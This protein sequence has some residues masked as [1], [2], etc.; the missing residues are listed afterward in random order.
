[1][2]VLTG[3]A[4]RVRTVAF[5]PDGTTLASSAGRGTRVWLWDLSTGKVRA[6][7]RTTHHRLECITFSAAAGLMATRDH[8]GGVA[9]W[10]IGERTPLHI[11]RN[12]WP[13]TPPGSWSVAF[14]PDGTTLATSGGS[15]SQPRNLHLLFF[16]TS[17]GEERRTVRLESYLFSLA[18]SPD[19]TTL[20]TGHSN[21]VLAF[22]DAV[23]R[24]Q[25]FSQRIPKAAPR[26][27]VFAENGA[28]LALMTGWS[29]TLWDVADRRVRAQLRGHKAAVYAMAVSPDGRTLATGSLDGTVRLWDIASGRQRAAF[30]WQLGNIYAL[31]F[32]PD[33]MRIAAGGHTGIVVW[34]NDDD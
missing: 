6:R 10:M 15:S 5:T 9:T 27:L 32:A 31:A 23:T 22:W 19:G 20:V 3:H 30:D 21:R 14:S 11:F 25:I 26:G 29:V 13:T 17:S 1:M 8:H 12:R 28:T 16:D 34:D 7:L 24:E 33:G 4:S 2:I 18:Y